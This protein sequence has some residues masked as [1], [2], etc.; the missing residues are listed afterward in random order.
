MAGTKK[1][2]KKEKTTKRKPLEIIEDKYPVKEF[3]GWKVGDVVWGKYHDG[4]LIYGEIMHIYPDD[5]IAPCVTLIDEIVGGYRTVRVS[6][7]TE[8]KPKKRRVKKPSD[9][10]S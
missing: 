8:K 5:E 7:L 10:K 3:G 2:K 1:T 4:K 6:S 9:K